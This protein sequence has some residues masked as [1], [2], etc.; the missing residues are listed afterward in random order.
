MS[1]YK[2]GAVYWLR[3]TA[4]DGRE[5]RES[6]QT[7]DRRQ[8]QKLHDIR[9]ADLWRQVKWGEQPRHIWQEVV[10]RWLEEHSERR[11]LGTSLSFLRLADKTLGAL[12]LDEITK[13]RLTAMLH[14]Y[15][16][17]GVK[18]GTANQLIGTIRGGLECGKR[19][20]MDTYLLKIVL[21][22]ETCRRLRWLTREEADR[23]IEE[24]PGYLAAMVRFALATGLRD[25][26]ICKLEW[27]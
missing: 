9:K 12:W 25:Q 23:L 16:A 7:T 11:G 27:N 13:D 6:A 2:R 24:L 4:P 22:P 1:I 26:N 18:N 10:V 8:A 21:L 5:I 20:G 14:A 19:L 17:T 15:R 3:F